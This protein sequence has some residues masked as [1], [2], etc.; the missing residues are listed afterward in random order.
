MLGGTMSDRRLL[1]FLPAVL[2]LLAGCGR[3]APSPPEAME[4]VRSTNVFS[5]RDLDGIDHHPFDSPDVKAVVLVFV[6]PDCPIANGYT[7]EINALAAKNASRGV[8]FYLVQVDP[9][10]TVAQARQHE[11]EF[12]YTFPVVLDAQHDLVRR[13][14][15]TRV[16]EAAVFTPDGQRRYRGRIDDQY[17]ALGKRRLQ[18]TS[19][20]LRDALDAVLAHRPI[21][22]PITEA[23]GCSI[24][25]LST[26]DNQP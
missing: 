6:L 7:P 4:Q 3:P 16:P 9:D 1:H 26:R 10:L 22:N 12:G 21:A 15:V 17:A 14:G 19:H 23:V 13:S 5:L 11:R 25:P 24:P 2:F 18:S 20:D 8:R